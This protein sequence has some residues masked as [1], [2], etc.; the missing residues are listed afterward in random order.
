MAETFERGYWYDVHFVHGE[1][2]RLFYFFP[3]S[4]AE[5]IL[6]YIRKILGGGVNFYTKDKRCVRV[7]L[8]G[9]AAIEVADTPE[10]VENTR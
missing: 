5:S 10:N 1:T 4:D 2:R 7:Y 6:D 3:G 9:V 8:R